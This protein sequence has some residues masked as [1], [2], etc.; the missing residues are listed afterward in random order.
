MIY[1][2]DNWVILKIGGAPRH[3]RVLGGWFGGYLRGNSWRLNS[4]IKRHD[5]DGDYWTFYGSSGSP[6]K[7]YVDN[8]RMNSTM[9]GVYNQLKEL[10]G[11]A[12]E[13]LEDQEWNKKTG[14]G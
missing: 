3:Y 13:V 6:Y 8:Y 11:Y 1:E 14:I 4:G 12:V 7:C 9:L 10:D 5:F 2:P